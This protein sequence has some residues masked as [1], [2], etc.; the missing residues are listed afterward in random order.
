MSVT[1][2]CPI[3]RLT[4]TDLCCRCAITKEDLQNIG[5]LVDIGRPKTPCTTVACRRNRQHIF[6][7]HCMDRWLRVRCVC[8]LDNL[9][10]VPEECP[11]LSELAARKIAQHPELL[12]STAASDL[13]DSEQFIWEQL[14]LAAE[15]QDHRKLAHVNEEMGKTFALVFA[16]WNAKRK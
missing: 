6:H 10:W 16:P 1:E 3:C 4:L 5:L 2:E 9:E 13:G 12:L 15:R 14:Y 11:K 8:P 7:R